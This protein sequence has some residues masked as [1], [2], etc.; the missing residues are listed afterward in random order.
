MELCIGVMACSAALF[1]MYLFCFS[2][3]SGLSYAHRTERLEF[4]TGAD[5]PVCRL[6]AYLN[7]STAGIVGYTHIPSSVRTDPN[8]HLRACINAMRASCK[9]EPTT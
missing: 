2:T 5:A 6:P 8:Y 3:I 1:I 9:P 7:A 4:A